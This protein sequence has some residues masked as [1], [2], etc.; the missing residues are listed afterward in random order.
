MDNMTFLVLCFSSKKDDLHMWSCYGNEGV[1]IEF[2]EGKLKA[3]LDSH[4]GYGISEKI[5][6]SIPD[7]QS[8]P[9]K[10]VFKKVNYYSK[11]S[12]AQYFDENKLEGNIDDFKKIFKNSPFCKSEFFECEEET[13]LVYTLV[14]DVNAANTVNYLSLLH[15]N[16]NVKDNIYFKSISTD[17][18]LHKMVIDLPIETNLI[19]SIILGPNC[20]L[21]KKDIK[22]LLII[23][24]IYDEIE[25]ERSKGSYR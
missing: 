9:I 5:K 13:R 22:E 19:K 6:K 23:N 4:I 15:D 24:G 7:L 18:Y 3:Y 17:K 20:K 10:L 1:S 25:V 21:T 12:I 16:N 11:N 14:H 2:D 8:S